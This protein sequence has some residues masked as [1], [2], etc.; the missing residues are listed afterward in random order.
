M[1]PCLGVGDAQAAARMRQNTYSVSAPS[2][3]VTERMLNGGI[4]SSAIFISGHDTP[5]IRHRKT[6]I[7]P[8]ADVAVR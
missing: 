7:S 2:A 5:Q 6:S 3:V 4:S 1:P 8:R